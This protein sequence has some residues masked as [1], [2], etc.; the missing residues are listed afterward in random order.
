MSSVV[1]DAGGFVVI[2]QVTPHCGHG[3]ESEEP[4]QNA[5][6]NMP[7]PVVKFYRGEP[8]VLGI[9]QIFSGFLLLSLGILFLIVS[10]DLLYYMTGIV[11]LCGLPIW[12]GILF[13]ISGSLSVSASVKP[14]VGKVKSSLVMNIFSCLAAVPGIIITAMELGL[15]GYDYR[16]KAYCAHY[17]NDNRCIGA[18][19]ST[20]VN[21]GILSYFL[22]LFILMFC[23][24]IS[25]SVF[26]CKTV[27]RTSFQE[28][29]V[30]I[31]Q[32]TSLNV[33]DTTRDVPPN[34]TQAV[35]SDI[36][37]QS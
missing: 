5:P 10:S 27:C 14:T 15:H 30:V 23:I 33:S 16:V 21:S 20:A 29:S 18:F 34:Y 36:K 6:A 7:K 17:N 22:L 28:I 4:S 37:R 1:S 26:A 11:I 25:T 8:E 24:S 9:T 3:S 32:T 12:S 13:I 35:T 31:Y 19:N 2:S